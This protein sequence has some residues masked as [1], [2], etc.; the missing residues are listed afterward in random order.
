MN[1][2]I[3]QR[4]AVI[5]ETIKVIRAY[6]QIRNENRITASDFSILV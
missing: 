4:E 2:K 6:I 3:N 1:S 5:D